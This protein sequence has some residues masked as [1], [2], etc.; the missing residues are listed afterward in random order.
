MLTRLQIATRI[1]TNLNDGAGV[2]FD[3]PTINESIQDAYDELIVDTQCV[4]SV[5]QVNFLDNHIYYDLYN[6]IISDN[7]FYHRLSRIYNGQTNRWIRCVDS[8][9]L[10]KFRF[11]W[12]ASSGTPWFA[13]I[14]N[15]Q[16]LGFFPHY[17]TALGTFDIFYKIG[18]DYLLTDDQVLQIPQEF[19]RA[20]ECYGTADLLECYQ[21]FEKAQLYWDEYAIIKQKL[22]DYVPSRSLP[23]KVWQYNDL[24]FPHYGAI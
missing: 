13:Y 9:V 3:I 23:D 10:D 5:F 12:E 19:I 18:K 8:R 16:Y 14:V 7:T 17:L 21:E 6:G 24:D 1:Q 4:E 11:D 2:F 22:M 20:V 15:F